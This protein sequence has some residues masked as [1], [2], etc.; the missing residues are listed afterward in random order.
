MLEHDDLEE[1][2][3]HGVLDALVGRTREAFREQPEAPLAR[4]ADKT[5]H[6]L[7]T[8]ERWV[9]AIERRGQAVLYGP[10]GVGKS[11]LARELARHL[12][13][14]GDGFVRHLVLHAAS[15][16]EDF[17]QGH[18]PVVRKDG[19]TWFPLVRGRFVQFAEEALR[20]RGTC[21]L[22]LDEM[23]RADVGRVLGE[24]VHLLEHRGEPLPLAAGDT[25]IVLAQ[26][27]RILGTMSSA[28]PRTDDADLVLRR[29]FAY[30]RVSPEPNVL[31]AF[32]RDTGFEVEGLLA[33]LARLEHV[34]RDPDRM[35]GLS[36]FLRRDLADTL[37]D[38]WRFEVEPMLEVLLREQPAERARFRWES[39]RHRIAP[40]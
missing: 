2:S 13:G 31:R 9:A 23:H 38:I 16:Y 14:G 28:D 4:I 35:L 26:N 29:R 18:R 40:R 12:V 32:H 34:V 36:Y 24:L 10:P 33:V 37:E 20:R 8:L 7:A 1:G 11:H 6:D 27:I 17:V 39:V 21:V 19:T 3:T 30:L 22:I 25:S 5:G 15:S